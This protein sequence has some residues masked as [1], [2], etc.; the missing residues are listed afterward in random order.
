MKKVNHILQNPKYRKMIEQINIL[1]ADRPYCRHGL[2]HLLDVARIAYIISLENQYQV[3]KEVTYGAALLHDIG[4]AGQY[5]NGIPHEVESVRIAPDIWQEAG[6]SQEEIKI[7]T[8][9]VLG[10]RKPADTKGNSLKSILYIADKKSR[11]CFNC[12]VDSTCN[13]SDHKRNR[14][15]EY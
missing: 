6:Y 2:S 4:K 10:H 15:L 8:E 13:W 14:Q 3:D 9:A 7:M 1:E 11:A 12:E 5:L